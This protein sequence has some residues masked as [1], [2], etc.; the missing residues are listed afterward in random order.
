MTLPKQISIELPAAAH[1]WAKLFSSKQRDVASGKQVYL[2]TLSVFAV[3][4]YLNSFG[5]A[6]DLEGSNSWYPSLTSSAHS[7]DLDL[8]DLGKVEC[9]AILPDAEDLLLPDSAQFDR[10]AYIAVQLTESMDSVSLLGYLPFKPDREFGP[11]NGLNF[12]SLQPI[13]DFTNYLGKIR[14]G[15]GIF[16]DESDSPLVNSLL[17]QIESMSIPSFIAGSL[18]IHTSTS[19]GRSQTRKMQEFLTYSI[20]GVTSSVRSARDRGKEAEPKSIV[21]LQQEEQIQDLSTQWLDKLN[22]VWA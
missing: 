16:D 8:L 22:S 10:I 11:D 1:S 18:Y 3:D 17:E 7:A 2:N 20:T 9:C 21:E 6:T 12:S 4:H 13:E 5:I 19:I 14:D 15:Y